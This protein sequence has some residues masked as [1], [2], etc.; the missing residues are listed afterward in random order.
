V[1]SSRAVERLR[2]LT[3][4]IWNRQ[5]PW[6]QRLALIRRGIAALAPDL[7]ALQEVLHHDASPDDQATE[8]AAGLDYHV[9]FGPAWHIGGGLHFGNAVL[10]RWPIVARDLWPLPGNV[11][12]ETR[13]LLHVDVDSP[14][15]RVPFFATH[16]NWKLHQASVRV[17]QV[18][19]IA[20][21]VKEVAPVGGFPPILAGDFNA[22][23][24]SDEIRFLRGHHVVDGT[25]V[26]F[27]DCF[28]WAGDGGPGY[29]F[30]RRNPYAA[31]VREPNR[32]LDYI[33]VRGPDRSFRG[34][35]L[36]ARVVLDEADEGVLP[37]DHFG[38][39]AEIQAAP[40]PAG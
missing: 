28:H 32:R 12:E 17:R 39:Y 27:A 40:R 3:L 19:F 35:P 34:E 15:G 21:R 38:V 9:A 29:T 22:E 6:E 5:G 7:V 16:L 4:N 30:A 14:F 10:A 36:V 31:L 11:D 18:A 26:F 24:D 1:L 23:P 2:I 8:I 33:F 37:S 25:S 13:A 20:E